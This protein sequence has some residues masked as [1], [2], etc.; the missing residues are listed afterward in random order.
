MKMVC[1]LGLKPSKIAR[2]RH[3]HVAAVRGR[4]AAAGCSEAQVATRT[5]DSLSK[6]PRSEGFSRDL[7]STRSP[8]R[9]AVQ[10]LYSVA[11]RSRRTAREASTHPP[12][13]GQRADAASQAVDHGA[14][15]L[16]TPHPHA[17]PIRRCSGP[18]ADLQPAHTPKPV[19]AEVDRLYTQ[20]KQAVSMRS[21]R[22]P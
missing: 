21:A 17:C 16:T 13:A 4:P 20:K 5:P 18:S 6:R 10:P 12:H 7:L 14:P 8:Q 2:H 22:W 11:G 15:T 3:C 1:V 19:R 9:V